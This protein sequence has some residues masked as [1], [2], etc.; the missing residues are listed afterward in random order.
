MSA[1]QLA[2]RISVAAYAVAAG[3][4]LGVQQVPQSYWWASLALGLLFGALAPVLDEGR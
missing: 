2:R 1:T 3:I 4:A